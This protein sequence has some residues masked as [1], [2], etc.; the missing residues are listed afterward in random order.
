MLFFHRR[1]EKAAVALIDRLINAAQLIAKGHVYSEGLMCS[2]N[3]GH[4]TYYH[5]GEHYEYQ[6]N[7]NNSYLGY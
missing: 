6:G 4:D 1:E 7:L 3:D 5:R 2:Q